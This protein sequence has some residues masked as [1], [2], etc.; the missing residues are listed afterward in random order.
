MILQYGQPYHFVGWL[1]QSNSNGTTITND[2][3]GRGMFV[4][5]ENV[6]SL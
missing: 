4:S 1:I 6:A 2:A 3:T 5:V